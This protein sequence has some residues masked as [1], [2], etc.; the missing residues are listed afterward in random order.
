MQNKFNSA[1]QLNK[2]IESLRTSAS[3]PAKFHDLKKKYKD[4]F[5]LAFTIS[6]DHIGDIEMGFDNHN[7]HQ[8]PHIHAESNH[9]RVSLAID[10]GNL[11]HKKNRNLRNNVLTEIKKWIDPRKECL[12]FIYENIQN[13]KSAADFDELINAMKKFQ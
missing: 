2:C 12:K 10:N 11:L 5:T 1:T 9:V 13:C 3:K 6:V 7:N 4:R 8:R